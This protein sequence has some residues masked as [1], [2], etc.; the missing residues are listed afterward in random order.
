MV[1]TAQ[2]PIL[3]DWAEADG[4]WVKRGDVHA[5]EADDV[6]RAQDGSQIRAALARFRQRGVARVVIQQHVPGTVV[7][8]YG[9]RGGFFFHVPPDSGLV[10]SD[11]IIHRMEVLGAAA[12]RVLDVDVYGGDC[13]VDGGSLVIIDLND[14][15]SYARCRFS[16]AAA[17]AAHVGAQEVR[18]T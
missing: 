17:I 14:W 5:T 4:A 3:P 11:D 9:V 2:N 15:P 16:A 8:F 12:A 10:L 6:V 1:E 18:C 7:K 13:V